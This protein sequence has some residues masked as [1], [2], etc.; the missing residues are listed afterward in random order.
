ML[1]TVSDSA[2]ESQRD[3]ISPA[4]Q[5]HAMQFGIAFNG[6]Q[7]VYRD[8]KY[9]RLSDAVAYAELDCAREHNS[10]LPSPTG[11][12]IARPLPNTDDQA[13]MKQYGIFFEDW[14]YRF[15]EFRYDHLSDAVNYALG[16]RS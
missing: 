5:N 3:D 15:H 9:D 7:F 4:A 8:F 2:S 6:T 1:S 13:L 14:R 12:W 10:P 11:D 16:H